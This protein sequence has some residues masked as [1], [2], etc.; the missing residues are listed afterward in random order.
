M[1]LFFALDWRWDWNIVRRPILAVNSTNSRRFHFQLRIYCCAL[2]NWI[3]LFVLYFC[4][5]IHTKN[6]LAAER[7]S[8][9]A[10]ISFASRLLILFLFY[11]ILFVGRSKCLNFSSK[12]V[13]HR[14]AKRGLKT[15]SQL[16]SLHHGFVLHLSLYI[17]DDNLFELIFNIFVRLFFCLTC[18]YFR[19]N[20]EVLRPSL[21]L[22]VWCTLS[23]PDHVINS[24]WRF[25]H[26]L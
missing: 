24:L 12:F 20:L 25:L 9:Y 23:K 18:E 26:L 8:S 7:W 13:R 14:K 17:L 21:E 3:L 4:C 10:V 22:D 11:L 16:N 15:A 6:T 2:K 1:T 5:W 19:V